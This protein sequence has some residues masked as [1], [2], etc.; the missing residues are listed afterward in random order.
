MLLAIDLT[1]TREY[2]Q[3]FLNA[4]GKADV[5]VGIRIQR[6]GYSCL[7]QFNSFIYQRM[8]NLLFK[9]PLKDVNWIA[10]YRH[11]YLKNI[12]IEC[13]GIVM[14]LEILLKLRDQQATFAQIPVTQPKRPGHK[15]PSA[16]RFSIMLKT[17]FQFIGFYY[18]YTFKRSRSSL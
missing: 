1:L 3:P 2:L 15:T 18:R 13:Q 16:A 11:T 4:L 6:E 7:M 14:M 9:L 10:C 12:S 17:L 5:L 8:V